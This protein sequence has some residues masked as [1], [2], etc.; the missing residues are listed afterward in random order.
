[1]TFKQKIALGCVMAF[2]IFMIFIFVPYTIITNPTEPIHVYDDWGSSTDQWTSTAIPMN[3]VFDKPEALD[4]CP[5]C[6]STEVY[7]GGFVQL[8][9][10]QHDLGG[11]HVQPYQPIPVLACNN[12]GAIRLDFARMNAEP[13]PAAESL[14]ETFK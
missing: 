10:S 7:G 4:R 9:I 11:R 14:L 2:G 5:Y 1:M 12:C 8:E 3:E 13:L 6:N